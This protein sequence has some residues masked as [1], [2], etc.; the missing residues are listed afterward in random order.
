MTEVI[1][2]QENFQDVVL[3]EQQLQQLNLIDNFLEHFE[4]YWYIIPFNKALI[5]LL[6]MNSEGFSYNLQQKESKTDH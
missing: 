2:V 3:Q 4:E 5:L 6:K 1:L